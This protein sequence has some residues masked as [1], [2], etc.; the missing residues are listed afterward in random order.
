M[1]INPITVTEWT[2]SWDHFVKFGCFFWFVHFS[3]W[4]QLDLFTCLDRKIDA[5]SQIEAWFK[6]SLGTTFNDLESKQNHKKTILLNIVT[7]SWATLHKS[8]TSVCYHVKQRPPCSQR[9]VFDLRPVADNRC[10]SLISVIKLILKMTRDAGGFVSSTE[11]LNQGEEH[12]THAKL[13]E[14]VKNI[15]AVWFWPGAVWSWDVG[16]L[17]PFACKSV[18][19]KN[20]FMP[21]NSDTNHVST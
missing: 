16:E 12:A 17:W 4:L 1:I 2:W 11:M 14:A 19:I 8:L 15:G 18:S 5:W 10:P 20:L 3:D 9:H 7:S 21:D 6:K 13:R